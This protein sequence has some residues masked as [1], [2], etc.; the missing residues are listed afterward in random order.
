MLRYISHQSRDKDQY[1]GLDVAE[2]P[3]E[4]EEDLPVEGVEDEG[5][6]V[7]SKPEHPHFYLNIIIL[8]IG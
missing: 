2:Y 7:S 5:D 6:D 4:A 3:V 1:M 8:F